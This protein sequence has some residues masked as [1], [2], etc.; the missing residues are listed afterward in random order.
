MEEQWRIA[1]YDSAWGPLF[2][3]TGLKLREALRENALRIDHVGST[4]IVG[5][6]AKPI[7]DIQISVLNFENLPSYQHE[8]ENVGFV[9]RVENPDQ[10]KRYFREAPG[11]RR[12][13]VHVRQAGSFS[14]QMTLL[15]RD[16]LREHPLDC[17]KYAEEKH[18]LMSVYRDQRS[19]YVEGKG[20][21]V[22]EIL[23]KA[24]LWSQEVGWKPADSDV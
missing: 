19:K 3:E 9:F 18:R 8:I 4:S 15:F 11:N 17:V 21:V 6:D 1:T 23:Q 10:S 16:Y 5:M 24:H 12:T 7:I 13:H 20:P 14:E 2:Y 22:W